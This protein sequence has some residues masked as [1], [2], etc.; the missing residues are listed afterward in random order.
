MPQHRPYDYDNRDATQMYEYLE[1]RIEALKRHIMQL[2][3]E[4]QMLRLK[5]SGTESAS[6]FR[7]KPSANRPAWLNSVAR[8]RKS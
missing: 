8:E 7:E 4:N 5:T 3:A 1:A 6:C 2:Q